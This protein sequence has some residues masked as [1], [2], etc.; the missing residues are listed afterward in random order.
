MLIFG[1]HEGERVAIDV[2]IGSTVGE[3]K[4]MI[5]VILARFMIYKNKIN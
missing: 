4:K 5:Q 1:V 2:P 3:V